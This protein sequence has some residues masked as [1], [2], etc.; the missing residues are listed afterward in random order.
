MNTPDVLIIGSGPAGLTAGLYAGRAGFS[1]SLLTGPEKGGKLSLTDKIE[2]FPCFST[3]SGIEFITKLEQ[4]AKEV[5]VSFFNENVQQVALLHPPFKIITEVQTW[6]PKS[7]IIAMGTQ[8]KWLNLPQ[9]EM[10]KGKGISVCATCD[11]FF[12]KNKNVAVIGG[13][14]TALYESLYL[15]NIAKNVYLLTQNKQLQGEFLLRQ[16]VLSL[17]NILIYYNTDV[18]GF[19]GNE[20]LTGL[21]IKN[22]AD[23]E[24][25]ILS[26]EGCF[27]AVG[28]VPNTRLFQNQLLVDKNGYIK[29]NKQTMQTSI[30]GIYA[31]G[32]IQET[33]YSQA[34]I[35]SA[36]GARAAMSLENYLKA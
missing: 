29:T 21:K 15:T 5:G 16:K 27:E 32:D 28:F 36:S 9:E 14:N 31:C 23:T 17:A 7:V 22:K 19:V 26:V 13:G 10:Y 11:G 3:G 12:Y 20:K 2:N 25:K 6:Q 8:V 34:L 35:A 30:K 33:G 4:Q 18:L 24:E 1:V